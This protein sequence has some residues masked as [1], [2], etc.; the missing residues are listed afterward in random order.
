MTD[1]VQPFQI[2]VKSLTGKTLTF[3]IEASDITDVIK[4]KIMGKVGIPMNQQRLIFSG[5]Q[6]EDGRLLSSYK[7]QKASTVHLVMKLP[8]AGKRASTM[9]M[10][11]DETVSYTHLTLPTIYSV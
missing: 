11:K 1:T 2:F 9:V 5:V 4:A 6:L 3:L 7:L 10:N 8:G